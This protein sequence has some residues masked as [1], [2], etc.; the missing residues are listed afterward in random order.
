[1]I[2]QGGLHGVFF[3]VKQIRKIFVHNPYKRLTKITVIVAPP[4]GFCVKKM[5][6][7]GGQLL[8]S[9]GYVKKS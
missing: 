7:R 5:R 1:M 6:F 3:P 8:R 2:D 9:P 4:R